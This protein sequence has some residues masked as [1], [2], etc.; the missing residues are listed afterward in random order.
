MRHGIDM[1][2]NIHIRFS[3]AHAKVKYTFGNQNFIEGWSGHL[4]GQLVFCLKIIT[5]PIGDVFGVSMKRDSR[6][7]N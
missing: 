5:M 7:P 2:T 3:G 4:L 1:L 6:Q